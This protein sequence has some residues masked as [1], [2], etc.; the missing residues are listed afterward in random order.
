[1]EATIEVGLSLTLALAN[2]GYRSKQFGSKLD[3][4]KRELHRRDEAN[5]SQSSSQPSRKSDE[6][7]GVFPVGRRRSATR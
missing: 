3:L 5:K 1:M 4:V 6:L 2:L 7:E